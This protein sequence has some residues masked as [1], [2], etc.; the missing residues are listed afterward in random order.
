LA[1]Y[2]YYEE[3]QM[4]KIG[5][6]AR[7]GQVSVKTL[8]YYDMVGLLKPCEV[9]PSSGYRYYTFDMLPKLNRILALKELGLSLDQVKQLL[10]ADLSAQ[11]LR[12]M[13]R[14]K[15]VEIQ[16]QMAGEKEKL[17]RVEARLQ[18]IEKEKKMPDYEVVIKKIEPMRVAAV[19]DIIPAYP[20]QGHLW[21]ELES[22]LTLHKITPE[23]PCFS[24][25]YSD[26]PDVD[27]QVCEPVNSP[28]PHDK[29]V[30]QLL[31]PRIEDM[32]SVVH[33]GPFLTIG[34]AYAAVIKWIE[35]NGYR[36]NG[37]PR[38]IYLRPAENGSQTDPDT[39]TEIQFPIEKEI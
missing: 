18:M 26:Q 9:D 39:V 7:I 37:P 27:T 31:L 15:Q 35:T 38:E 28:I 3:G 29:R 8:R 33:N 10:E 19:R 13:L 36:V 5:D 1:G 14:L 23:G 4:L 12:G 25:Y 34:E 24:I 17:A 2:T 21:E 20:E 16:Q 6:F 30:K 22:F 11:E 32:A